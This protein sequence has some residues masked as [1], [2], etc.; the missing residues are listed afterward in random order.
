VKVLTAGKL[1]A[2]GLSKLQAQQDSLRWRFLPPL[3]LEHGLR[4][5]QLGA[6][7]VRFLEQ[8][9]AGSALRVAWLASRKTD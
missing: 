3:A 7:I 2:L 6:L 4:E 1:F 8:L 9:L 5:V